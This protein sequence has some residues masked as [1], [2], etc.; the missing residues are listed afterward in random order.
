[1]DTKLQS[2]LKTLLSSYIQLDWLAKGN[3]PRLVLQYIEASGGLTLKSIWASIEAN[4]EKIRAEA[5]KDGQISRVALDEAAFLLK[6]LQKMGDKASDKYRQ[7]QMTAIEELTDRALIFCPTTQLARVYAFRSKVLLENEKPELALS[8]MKEA[9]RLEPGS[10]LY[11]RTMAHILYSDLKRPKEALKYIRA[12]IS[13]ADYPRAAE[14]EEEVMAAETAADNS[15]SESFFYLPSFIAQLRALEA[16]ILEELMEEEDEE[17][18]QEE[19]NTEPPPAKKFKSFTMDFR[20]KVVQQGDNSKGRLIIAL[21]S[22]P[23]GTPVFCEHVYSMVILP[24]M[25]ARVCALCAR[26]LTTGRCVAVPCPDCT[27]VLYCSASC[28]QLHRSQGGGHQFGCRLLGHLTERSKS[29]T[30]VFNLLNRIGVKGVLKAIEESGEWA[31]EEEE[32]EENAFLYDMTAYSKDA[33]QRFTAE[34][35]KDE[36]LRRQAYQAQMTL[37]SHYEKYPIGCLSSAMINA[38]ECAITAAIAQGFSRW[39]RL[40]ESIINTHIFYSIRATFEQQ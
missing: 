29:T 30:S 36:A 27:E 6:K 21:D 24:E 17:K 28:A 12:A 9:V 26:K 10:P 22:L 15:F 31:T 7:Q 16:A 38:I 2:Q 11:H 19:E 32:K 1:M 40:S 13:L 35:H 23:P 8:A 39:S 5:G 14:E 18:K 25:V 20:C 3:D 4:L 34:V 33:D 37:Y